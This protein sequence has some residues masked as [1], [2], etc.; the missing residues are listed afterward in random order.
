MGSV[1]IA[2]GV[3]MVRFVI[4]SVTIACGVHMVRFV[5][6]SV[7]IACGVSKDSHCYRVHYYSMWCF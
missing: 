3:H 4:G 2:C 6:R 5:I 7:T 1:T